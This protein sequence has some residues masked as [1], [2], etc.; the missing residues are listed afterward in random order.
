MKAVKLAKVARL[1]AE[2][3]AQAEH[4]RLVLVATNEDRITRG[5]T[6]IDFT[7]PRE[8]V[9]YWTPP[10]AAVAFGPGLL[11]SRLVDH[12]A[13][14]SFGLSAAVAGVFFE[15]GERLLCRGW[16]KGTDYSVSA[17]GLC[18]RVDLWDHLA[19]RIAK[20]EAD[21][22]ARI[23]SGKPKSPKAEPIQQIKP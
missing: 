18:V 2:R 11:N 15:C 10:P 20:H 1:Q 7:K 6:P 3:D 23:S 13:L 9:S 16:L 4:S 21:S 5:L 22:K 17:A 8:A 12:A 14:E 19:P